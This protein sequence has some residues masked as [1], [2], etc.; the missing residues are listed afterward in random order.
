MF[1][2]YFGAFWSKHL[3]QHHNKGVLKAGDDSYMT[4]YYK[5]LRNT[6]KLFL[7]DT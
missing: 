2:E 1:E 7:I 5:P 4:E 6:T 3:Y